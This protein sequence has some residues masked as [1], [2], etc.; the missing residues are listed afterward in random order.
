MKKNIIIS[1]AALML[2]LSVAPLARAAEQAPPR[3]EVV[4]SGVVYAKPDIAVLS[5]AVETNRPRA[6]DAVVENAQKADTL[7][8]ALKNLMGKEDKIQTSGY[9]VHPVY[10]QGDRLRPS[11]YRVSNRV[12]VE[13]RQIENVGDFIDAA[14]SSGSGSMGSLQF[15]SS[16]EAEYQR[17]AAAQAVGRARETA[18]TL[19]KAAGVSLKSIRQIRYMPQGRPMARFMA[20]AAVARAQTPIEPGELTIEAEV[21]MVFEIE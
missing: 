3:L 10:N 9:S 16:Q 19:A 13:T 20:E 11:G 12:V 4:G 15:R 7:L 6:A 14:A 18:E 17:Q 2:C 8:K 21:T 5:F 1:A